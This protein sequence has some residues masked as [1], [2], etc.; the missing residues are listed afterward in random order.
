MKS[1]KIE[2]IIEDAYVYGGMNMLCS[3]KEFKQ[4]YLNKKDYVKKIM[5]ELKNVRIEK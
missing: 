1:I 4:I 2:K 3:H 5:H